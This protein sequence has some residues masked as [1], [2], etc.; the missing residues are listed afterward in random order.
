MPVCVGDAQIIYCGEE[1]GLFI[2]LALVFEVPVLYS[3]I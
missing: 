3:F 1:N 2:I